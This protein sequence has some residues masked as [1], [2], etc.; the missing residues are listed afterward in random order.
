MD[1]GNLKIVHVSIIH[2]MLASG[3]VLFKLTE[4][5]VVEG[6]LA[7]LLLTYTYLSQKCCP[8]LGWF[9]WIYGKEQNSKQPECQCY[10]FENGGKVI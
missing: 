3:H 5:L 8:G 2:I 6:R 4:K 10:G 7:P 9:P 1:K